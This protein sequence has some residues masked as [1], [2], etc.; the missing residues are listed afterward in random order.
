MGR[1]VLAILVLPLAGCPV[2]ELRPR[3][4]PAPTIVRESYLYSVLFACSTHYTGQGGYSPFSDDYLAGIYGTAINVHNFQ[5]SEATMTIRAMA[6]GNYWD[7][8]ESS[9]VGLEQMSV[10]PSDHSLLLR[11]RDIGPWINN[12]W[13]GFRSGFVE[14]ESPVELSVVAAY[15]GKS[16]NLSRRAP[17][18]FTDCERE[19]TLDVVR[20]TPFRV[21]RTLA[22]PGGVQRPPATHFGTTIPP[23]GGSPGDVAPRG[24]GDVAPP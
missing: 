17:G 21:T 4:I 3:P 23:R 10:L 12:A 19:I 8:G 24:T 18:G 15:T 1:L 9:V 7:A 5:P 14:I 22:P 20:Q 11:C 16:C 13:G 2:T 6:N